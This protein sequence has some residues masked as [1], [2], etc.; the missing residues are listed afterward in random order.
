VVDGDDHGIVSANL[1]CIIAFEEELDE[2]DDE[3]VVHG[4]M[5]LTIS[6]GES[7]F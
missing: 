1:E 3:G 6:C 2:V 4:L 7:I 5:N